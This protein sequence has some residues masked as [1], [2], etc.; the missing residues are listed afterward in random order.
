MS[1]RYVDVVGPL[2]KTVR[3][4]AV[5][6][7]V[8]A[9]PS[10]EDPRTDAARDRI[11]NRGYVAGLTDSALEGKRFG[12]VGEGWRTSFLPLAPETEALYREAIAVLLAQGA[13]V[14]DDPF[15]DTGFVEKYRER[16]GTRSGG[17]NEMAEYLEGLGEG[18]AFN[19]IREWEELSG[20][21]F[22]RGG[23]SRSQT[24]SPSTR[25]ANEPGER[26]DPDST[27]SEGNRPTFPEWRRE[28]LELFRT[29][30]NQHELDGLFF[31][32]AGAPIGALVED[33]E[34]PSYSPNNHPELP[35]NIVNDMGLPVVTVPFAYYE[36]GTPFVLAFIGDTWTEA[37]LLAF[38]YDLE[39]AAPGRIP[40]ALER[41]SGW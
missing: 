3:D 17:G 8:I 33:P 41:G 10:E 38:A 36:D 34:R 6:L 14:I 9:G 32:Q 24:P 37:D 19:S 40:P 2:A 7:D 20:E 28:I 5:A 15:R 35:S 18:A 16:R 1:A 29:V 31:P 30:L 22:R 25:S 13:Q 26:E 4:A 27:E 23:R 21:P 11:P 12:L 39:Q